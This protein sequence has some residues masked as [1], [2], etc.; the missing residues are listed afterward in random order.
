MSSKTKQWIIQRHLD[1]AL[2]QTAI[3]TPMAQH[4]SD[5]SVD[6]PSIAVDERMIDSAFSALQQGQTHYVDV[7]GIQPLRDKLAGFM[8]EL[9]LQGY[10]PVNMIVTAGVQE[11]RFLSLQ[12]IGEAQGGVGLPTIVDPGARLAIGVRLIPVTAIPA[13]PATGLATLDGIA[14][15]LAG[16]CKLVYLESPSRLTGA[17]YD[18]AAV[19]TIADL[20]AQHDAGAIWDQGLAP[21]TEG[22]VSLASRPGMAERVIALGEAWPGVG[23]ESWYLGYIATPTRWFEPM[24]SQKQVIAICTST[25]SQYAA[26]AAADVYAG[27]HTAQRGQLAASR[28]AAQASL[29]QAGALALPGGA[30]SVLAVRVSNAQHQALAK[31]GVTV[32]DGAAFGAAGVVRLATGNNAALGKA[33]GTVRS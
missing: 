19:Q 11:A 7:P 1:N 22:Y 23:L 8:T 30:A 3:H 12:M 4:A 29:E 27:C 24:R 17:A 26:L 33:I 14:A 20:L 21:W 10:D 5:I 16:G 6:Q 2:L 32:A 31:A 9:G 28:Q 25:A 15:T 13:D 18:A